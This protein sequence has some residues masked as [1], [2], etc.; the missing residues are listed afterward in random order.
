MSV[1]R[2]IFIMLIQL[3]KVVSHGF[4]LHFSIPVKLRIL[5]MVI[6]NLEN[7][8]S[9]NSHPCIDIGSYFL[10]LVLFVILDV[11]AFAHFPLPCSFL[12]GLQFFVNPGY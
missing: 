9:K 12:A 2:V 5:S 1:S 6:G 7:R 8:N 4:D 11:T 10:F 3:C